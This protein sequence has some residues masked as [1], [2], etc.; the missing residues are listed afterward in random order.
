VNHLELERLVDELVTPDFAPY[1]F[2][3][4]EVGRPSSVFLSL[5]PQTDGTVLATRGDLREKVE[6][7]VDDKGNRLVFLDE[8]SACEWAWKE[9]QSARRPPRPMSSDERART[10][11]NGEEKRILWEERLRRWDE[12]GE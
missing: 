3:W 8:N 1:M 6:P 9:I 5:I 2:A 12:E 11:A 10:L 7:W 4:V